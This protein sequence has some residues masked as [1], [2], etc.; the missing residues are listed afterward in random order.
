MK[1]EEITQRLFTT[2]ERQ[3][4]KSA[5]I[6]A[7][8]ASELRETIKEDLDSGSI[9]E[10]IH[11]Q[12]YDYFCSMMAENISWARSIIVVAAPQPVLEADFI[13]DGRRHSAIIPPTYDHNIDD[14]VNSAIESE[15]R[16]HGYK[17]TTANLPLKLLATRSGLA[18]YGRNNITYVEGLGS[19]HRLLAFYTD[20]PTVKDSWQ[21]PMELD[22]CARCKACVVK[23]PT[24]A[25]DPNEF[26]LRAE[27]CLTYHNESTEPF[28]EWINASWHHCLIGCMKCQI[29]CPANR[30]VRMW[31]K[32]FVEFT[33]A[34]STMILN[35][36]GRGELPDELI[37][38]FEGTD[39]LENTSGLS[40]NLRSVLS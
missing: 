37:S 28:S 36:A 38:K 40:R 23:C 12:Y 25:I 29:F 14:A 7:S 10:G 33:E 35:G 30:E 16:S 2:L 4:F 39:L 22:R 6:S 15:L 1:S 3:G 8:H 18:R 21:N 34:E 24:S 5:M 20:L 9:D 31:K 17:V 11:S 32:K 26:R 19:F 13:V 27:R